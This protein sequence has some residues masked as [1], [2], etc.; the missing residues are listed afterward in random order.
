MKQIILSV[1]VLLAVAGCTDRPSETNRPPE[2]VLKNARAEL[3]HYLTKNAMTQSEMNILSSYMLQ[4]ANMEKDII[5]YRIWNKNNYGK[6]EKE[7][8]SDCEAWEKRMEAEAKKPSQFEGGTLAPLDNNF[9]MTSFVEE[10]IDELRT[11]WIKK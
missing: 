5:E 1:L 9:R 2:D 3:K 7:F 4:L 6:I 11:R 8:Q 10:R